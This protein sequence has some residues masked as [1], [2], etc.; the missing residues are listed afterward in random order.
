MARF[1]GRWTEERLDRF[2]ESPSAVVPGTTMGFAGIDD[3]AERKQV[4]E[5]LKWQVEE[6]R[7]AR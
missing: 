5:L 3:A 1:G 6:Q 2:L 7:E 4:I